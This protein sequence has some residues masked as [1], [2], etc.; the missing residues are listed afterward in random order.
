MQVRN[1]CPE[2]SKLLSNASQPLVLS[3]V[4]MS[5]TLHNPKSLVIGALLSLIKVGLNRKLCVKLLKL[6]SAQQANT[7]K[8]LS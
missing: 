8:T 2:K 4:C 5:T 7:H 6:L 3:K 1:P